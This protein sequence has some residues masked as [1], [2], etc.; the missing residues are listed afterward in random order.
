MDT[1][2]KT[3][4][5]LKEELR[6]AQE[7]VAAQERE[8]QEKARA[9][10]AAEEEKI[11]QAEREA[12]ETKMRDALTP[13]YSAMREAGIACTLQ[14]A[15]ITIVGDPGSIEIERATVGRSDR[16]SRSTYTDGF[17]LILRERYTQDF[18][19][20]RYPQIK[21]GEF[22]VEKIVKT[23]QER[24]NTIA[25]RAK[26]AKLLAKKQASGAELA[27]ALKAELHLEPSS[28]LISGTYAVRYSKGGGRSEYHEC[29]AEPGHVYMTLGTHQ[30]N[31]AQV[32]VM[33][34]ALAEAE[35]LAT[36]KG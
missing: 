25:T 6:V 21:A 17:V 27:G 22:N 20:I 23:V 34:A 26:E 13:V 30:Y 11:R 36:K 31:A 3:V 19:K 7:A 10:K 9:E 24:L 29:T 4:E 28:S 1:T 16:W 14:G 15:S 2:T 18:P 32:R 33:Y 12:L 35:K 8:L 5:Q